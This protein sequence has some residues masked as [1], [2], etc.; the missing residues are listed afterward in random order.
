MGS[1]V[2]AAF[3]LLGGCT[4]SCAMPRMRAWQDERPSQTHLLFAEEL[5]WPSPEHG[6]QA[7]TTE[8]SYI[9]AVCLS[10]QRCPH[11][12]LPLPH[13]PSSVGTWLWQL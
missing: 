4:F 11:T 7:L 2:G 9:P 10:M 5:A 12:A 3:T 1:G 8:G 13:S 6:I